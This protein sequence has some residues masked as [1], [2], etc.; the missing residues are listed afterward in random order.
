MKKLVLFGDSIR[1]GYEPEV[2]EILKDAWEVYGPP[3]NGRF[4]A[5]TLNS[6]RFWVNDMPEADVVHFN[7]G[8]WDMGDDNGFGRPFTR[9]AE[10]KENLELIIRVIRKHYPEAKIAMATTTPTRD[11]DQK[12]IREYNEILKRVAEEQHIPVDD[13]YTLFAGKEDRYLSLDNLH[14]TK[15]GFRYAA[16]HVAGFVENLMK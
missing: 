7:C 9:P 5:Y 10:Y 8:L 14:F 15:E 6:I 13:L 16:E 12:I 1:M 11:R 4:S 2:R 3:E